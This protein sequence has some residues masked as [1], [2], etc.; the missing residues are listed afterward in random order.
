[1]KGWQG[2]RER[3]PEREGER[4]SEGEGERPLKGDGDTVGLDASRPPS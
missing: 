3:E 1:M 2:N 4:E